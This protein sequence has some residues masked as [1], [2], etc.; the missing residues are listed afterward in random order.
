MIGGLNLNG[1]DYRLNS[2]NVYN[3]LPREPTFI[4][5]LVINL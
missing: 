1:A 3:E 5:R 4:A 2:L